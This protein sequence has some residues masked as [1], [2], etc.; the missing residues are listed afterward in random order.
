MKIMQKAKGQLDIV[1]AMVVY[2]SFSLQ[3]FCGHL[4]VLI[5]ERR[6]AISQYPQRNYM[7]I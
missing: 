6:A 3:Y 4:S 1:S 7:L 2:Y 5:D